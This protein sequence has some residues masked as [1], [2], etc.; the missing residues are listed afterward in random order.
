[1]T[2]RLGS[3]LRRVLGW[4]DNR[5]PGSLNHISLGSHCHMAELLKST[6]LRTWSGPFDWIFSNP[7]MV[8]DCLKDDFALL[9]DRTE[10]ESTKLEERPRP[11]ECRGRH[12]GYAERHLIPFVF[13]HHDPAGDA[14]DY[15]FLERGVGRLRRALSM[16]GTENRFYLMASVPVEDA[17]VQSICDVLA[18][19]PSRNHLTFLQIAE[20]SQAAAIESRDL[21]RPD[22][23][24][25][26][27]A[28][29][30]ASVGLRFSDPSADA[31]I[32]RLP[33][34]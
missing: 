25:L 33:K 9:L 20:N 28:A 5:E 2:T 17:I 30:S 15:A 7:G 19:H 21:G 1:M 32:A 23:N 14:A 4:Q 34:A 13:N 22:L 31:L 16:A 11:D 24:W 12:R 6:G 3:A 10:L 29:R 8:L 26:R 27:V 18:R